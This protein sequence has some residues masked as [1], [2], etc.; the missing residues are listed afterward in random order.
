M[1]Y[2]RILLKITKISEGIFS[3]SHFWT[4]QFH[5]AIIIFL[6]VPRWISGIMFLQDD[7]VRKNLLL[8]NRFNIR[9][10]NIIFGIW[11]SWIFIFPYVVRKNQ[12]GIAKQSVSLP[13][14]PGTGSPGFRGTLFS[15][16]HTEKQQQIFDC[17]GDG[18]RLADRYWSF[19]LIFTVCISKRG[20]STLQCKFRDDFFNTPLVKKRNG[21]NGTDLSLLTIPV[22]CHK[23]SVE[24]LTRFQIMAIRPGK[25][26]TVTSYDQRHNNSYFWFWVIWPAT[27]GHGSPHGN[28]LRQNCWFPS[29]T[30]LRMCPGS[31]NVWWKF[32]EKTWKH[33]TRTGETV[34]SGKSASCL[35]SLI[36][37]G[38]VLLSG[39]VR[40][41]LRNCNTVS[42]NLRL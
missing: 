8:K 7:S 18:I 25:R 39:N 21:E 17:R 10:M 19:L 16:L 38:P 6:I 20:S 11:K 27:P 30:L 2:C 42:I 22:V 37:P 28:S 5:T 13:H 34:K 33:Q 1:N 12:S 4:I 3:D 14:G 35:I 31:G 40:I 26:S 29:V 32:P 23:G 15:E 9:I 24:S 41:F 36:V